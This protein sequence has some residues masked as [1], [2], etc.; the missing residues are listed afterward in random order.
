MI[1]ILDRTA[2]VEGVVGSKTQK[3][4][5]NY[6]EGESEGRHLYVSIILDCFDPYE[7]LFLTKL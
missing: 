2:T 6:I 1:N 7:I 4:G 3:V 5:T